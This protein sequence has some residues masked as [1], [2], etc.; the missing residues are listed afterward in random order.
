MI[1]YMDAASCIQRCYV[2]SFELSI[3]MTPHHMF[4]PQSTNST[5]YFNQ[6]ESLTY[7][8]IASIR[9]CIYGEFTFVVLFHS[10]DWNLKEKLNSFFIVLQIFHRTCCSN[11]M[12]Y[13]SKELTDFQYILEYCMTRGYILRHRLSTIVLMLRN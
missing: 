4:F 10:F 8:Y 2:T 13:K 3:C 5:N 7:R 12:K 6:S 1:L 9:S 11:L